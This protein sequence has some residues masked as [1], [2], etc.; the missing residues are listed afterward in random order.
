LLVLS[1]YDPRTYRH[2]GVKI[3]HVVIHKAEAA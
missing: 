2:P 1:Y 3:D